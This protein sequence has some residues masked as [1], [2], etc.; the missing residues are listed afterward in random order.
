MLYFALL[1]ALALLGWLCSRKGKSASL[2]NHRVTLGAKDVLVYKGMDI[3]RG[4]LD[5]I[6]DTD[7]RVLWAFVR[8]EY[9]EVR[10]VP[11]SED[12]VIWLTDD[13]VLK[14]RDVE[15]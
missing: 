2:N 9:G 7:K 4:I 6:V 11:Y 1:F 15:L 3:D 13:D 8:S 12:H 5:A 14:A 10:A